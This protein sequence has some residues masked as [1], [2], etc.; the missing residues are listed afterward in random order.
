MTQ[1]GKSTPILMGASCQAS[2]PCGP[3]IKVCSDW[4][5]PSACGGPSNRAVA[6]YQTCVDS[7]G[8]ECVNVERAPAAGDFGD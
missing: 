5:E 8:N 2:H 3:D 1:A 7:R 4:S 6:R